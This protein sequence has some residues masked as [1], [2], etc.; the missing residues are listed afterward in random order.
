M[1]HTVAVDREISQW[2][3]LSRFRAHWQLMTLLCVG[4][5]FRVLRVS[6]VQMAL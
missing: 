1:I 6:V 4:F 5:F 3:K 2:A